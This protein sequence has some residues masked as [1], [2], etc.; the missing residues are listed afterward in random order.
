MDTLSQALNC[1]LLVLDVN[2]PIICLVCVL[3]ILFLGRNGIVVCVTNFLLFAYEACVMFF[4]FFFVASC[5][6]C[7]PTIQCLG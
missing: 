7:I 2:N 3:I 6:S 4:F 1:W 5:Y